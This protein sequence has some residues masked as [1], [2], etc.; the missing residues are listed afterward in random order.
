MEKTGSG[1]A[2]LLVAYDGS[3]FARGA[4]SELRF[5]GLPVKAQVIIISVCEL[6][7]PIVDQTR[8]G[9]PLDKE[10]AEYFQK[11]RE[12][13]ERNMAETTAIAC[14]ARDE[15]LK[16]FPDWSVDVEIVSGSPASQI[17][18]K[19]EEFHPDIIV[20]GERGL[21]SDQ[22]VGLGSAAQT[23][24]SDAIC[25]VRI[26]RLKSHVADSPRR[27]M[28]GFDGSAGSMTAVKAVAS[29]VWKTKPEIR[30]VTVTDPFTLLKPGRA[31]DP[32][33]GMTE[34]LV[35]GEEKWVQTLAMGALQILRGS[36]LSVGLHL[37]S[38][39]SRMVLIRE[40]SEWDADAIF[41]GAHAQELKHRFSSL[42]CVAAAIANRASCSVE[43]VR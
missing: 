4:L 38:G 24:L 13:V 15:L 37:Y 17:L 8:G 41:L 32:I 21:S 14:Q 11:H 40:A 20:V 27:I 29:R 18:S 34:G 30:L 10:L 1:V 42:G 23:V 26:A 28:I 5:S 6:W 33:P 3:G 19:A 43:V 25:S 9:L 35:E 12:Q 31:F 36:D 7:L 2:K 16:Y 39:N 22:D